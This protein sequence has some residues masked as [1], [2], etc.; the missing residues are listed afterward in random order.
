[1]A[2]VIV[3]QL[4]P[5]GAV[6][7]GS[8]LKLRFG[9]NATRFSKDLD[10][11]RAMALDDYVDALEATLSEGWEGFT[12]LLAPRKPASPK[13]VPVP[14]V[15][16]PFDVKLSYNGKG[17]MT[18]PIEIGHNEIGDAE[19]PDFVVSSE[20]AEVFTALGFCAPGPIPLMRLDHQ[21][22]QKLHAV[23]GPGSERAHDLVDLQII[24]RNGNFD[25]AE[26]RE[27]CVRLFAY[28]KEQS[29]P[30]EIVANEGWSE[31]YNAAR[32][33]INVLDDVDDAIVWANNLVERID[34]SIS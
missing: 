3:G 34:S 33:G 20:M 24:V 19:D 11:A 23:S 22:A 5:D 31:L 28:R 7:G 21:V 12:G 10:T 14:Y 15:M 29:W 25:Y 18:V 17:W 4:L 8:A 6:K 26:T 16:Q 9:Q 13:G 1:M 2:N 27:T 30:P 32:T